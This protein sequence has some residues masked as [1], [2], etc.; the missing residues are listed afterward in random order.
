MTQEQKPVEYKNSLTRSIFYGI[1]GALIGFFLGVIVG[2]LIKSESKALFLSI[3]LFFMAFTAF[4]FVKL[5]VKIKDNI[6]IIDR[7]KLVG[8]SQNERFVVIFFSCVVP[9]I[10]GFFLYYYWL[11][12]YPLKAKQSFNIFLIVQLIVVP[13]LWIFF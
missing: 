3:I 8:L 10:S 11:K 4:I 13:L 9:I 6:K 7:T 2:S 12:T 5:S 1:L